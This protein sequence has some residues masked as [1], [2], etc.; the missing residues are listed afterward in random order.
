MGGVKFSSGLGL[1][2]ASLLGICVL[3]AGCGKEP[4]S[5][6]RKPPEVTVMT[7]TAR[8]TPVTFVRRPDPELPRGGNPCSRGR[9]PG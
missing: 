4:V 6:A 7:V 9:I 8:D 5:P 1:P 2:V 3:L